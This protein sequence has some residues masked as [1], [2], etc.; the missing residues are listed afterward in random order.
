MNYFWLDANAIAKRYVKEKGTELIDHLFTCV[1]AKRIVCL[2]DSMNETIFVI[3]KKINRKEI[4]LPEYE[5]ANQQFEAEVIDSTEVVQVHATVDQKK[6]ARQF[7]RVDGYSINSADGDILQ[8]ALDK[9]N[10]LRSDGHNLVLVSS[11]KRL[12]RAA[13]MER[14]FTFDPETD[15]RAYLDDLIN[16]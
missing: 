1:S 4:T 9:A 3:T 15:K 14:L 13:Q 2:F 10:E 8:C 5:Q 16:S 11:D 6:A 12:L 7:I